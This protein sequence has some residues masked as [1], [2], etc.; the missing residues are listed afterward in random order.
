MKEHEMTEWEAG[1]ILIDLS[2]HISD[3]ALDLS[4]GGYVNHAN[5][6]L[7]IRKIVAELFNVKHEGNSHTFGL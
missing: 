6:L 2:D 1:E 5:A 7:E 3:A 4:R